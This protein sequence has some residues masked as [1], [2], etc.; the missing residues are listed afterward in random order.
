[1][2][3]IWN[4][5]LSGYLNRS[6]ASKDCQREN[7]ERVWE[8]QPRDSGM[9]SASL[10]NAE[11]DHIPLA[12]LRVQDELRGLLWSSWYSHT[13]LNVGTHSKKCVLR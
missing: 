7:E 3:G 8:G 2:P 10:F 12:Q 5:S 4:K 1:M 13:S 6:G 9:F 11:R